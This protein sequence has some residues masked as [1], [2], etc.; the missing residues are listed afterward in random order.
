MSQDHEIP[1]AQPAETLAYQRV[2]DRADMVWVLL[3]KWRLE[4]RSE[5]A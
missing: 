4:P 3:K 5:S 1:E 2:P